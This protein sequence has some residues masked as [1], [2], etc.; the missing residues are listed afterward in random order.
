MRSAEMRISVRV[1]NAWACTS[2]FLGTLRPQIEELRGRRHGPASYG[3][4]VPARA[5][6]PGLRKSRLGPVALPDLLLAKAF[7][8]GVGNDKRRVDEQMSIR[9]RV[10][11]PLDSSPLAQVLST[12]VDPRERVV[13][14]LVLH[15][16]RFHEELGGVL[17]HF[18]GGDRLGADTFPKRVRRS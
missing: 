12:P 3:S 16:H 14:D 17:S 5:G 6:P 15:Q 7:T 13:L 10:I 4:P 18:P 9:R 11:D 2:P 1:A 8:S